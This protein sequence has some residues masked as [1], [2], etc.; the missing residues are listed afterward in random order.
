MQSLSL[1]L[2]FSD[3]TSNPDL[4]GFL[5]LPGSLLGRSSVGSEQAMF[6]AEVVQNHDSNGV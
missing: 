3:P 6:K 1:S 5:S 2:R 4:G